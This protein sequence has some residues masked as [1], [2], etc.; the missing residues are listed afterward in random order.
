MCQLNQVLVFHLTLTTDISKMYQAVKLLPKDKD[1][2]H[3]VWCDDPQ[4]S[5]P[6]LIMT[7]LTF[8]VSASSCAANMT[9]KQAECNG[10]H[11]GISF[12]NNDC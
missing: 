9:A 6:L 8:G 2:H 10:F 12:G 7:R 5:L 11:F 3:F 1:L 4:L